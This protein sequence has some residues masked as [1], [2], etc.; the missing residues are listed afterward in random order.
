VY[1]ANCN[2]QSLIVFDTENEFQASMAEQKTTVALLI[3]ALRW[4]VT[5]NECYAALKSRRPWSDNVEVVFAYCQH[6]SWRR[7]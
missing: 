3:H 5:R 7:M 4:K 1:L 6:W 2:L